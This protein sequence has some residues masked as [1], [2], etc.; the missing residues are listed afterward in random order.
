MLNSEQIQQ[1]RANIVAWLAGEKMKDAR[2]DHRNG[3]GFTVNERIRVEL[4]GQVIS[5]TEYLRREGIDDGMEIGEYRVQINQKTEQYAESY[6][7]FMMASVKTL[8]AFKA[9]GERQ[10]EIINWLKGDDMKSDVR[11]FRDGCSFSVNDRVRVMSNAGSEKITDFLKREGF[12]TGAVIGDYRIRLNEATERYPENI[13]F[14]VSAPVV[15]V[16][17]F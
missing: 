1:R 9:G 16:P 6:A 8:P 17:S 7:F 4:D 12:V 5:V 11:L 13:S 10:Q 15:A 2:R 3:G 14:F